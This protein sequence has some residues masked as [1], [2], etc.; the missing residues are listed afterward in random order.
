VARR[1]TYA[2][3]RPGRPRIGGE[4][5]ELVLRLARD[6]P[7]WGYQRIAGEL[8]GLG[9]PLSA[10]T[11]RKLLR[12]A[13]LGPAGKRAGLTW[14][15]FIRHQA[16]TMIACDFFTVDTV[17]ST[18]L[19]VRFFIELA[20]RR[21]HLAGCD[22]NPSGAWVARQARNLAWSFD[23]RASLRSLIHDRD[24]KFTDAFDEVFRSEGIEVIRTPF[25]APQANAFAERFVGT[26]RRECLDWIVILSRGQ[27]ERTLRT[28]VDHY[29][30]HRPHRALG[31]APPEPGSDLGVV[32]P[33]PLGRVRRQDRL[34][35]L[36]HEYSTAA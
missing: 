21:V 27:L 3:R 14:R 31:L 8:G 13:G 19:Y 30:G 36:V 20:S 26:I 9:A 25:N 12:E 4:I 32:A 24:S 10:T 5:R 35:G 1:W 15:E 34:G 29:N 16:A 28:Y 33:R 18:R 23:E 22:Q 6:N 7:R 17:R 2:Q 11:V